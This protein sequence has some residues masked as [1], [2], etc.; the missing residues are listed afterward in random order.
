[1]IDTGNAIGFYTD[2]FGNAEVEEDEF[3]LKGYEIR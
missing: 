2:V 1:M 3:E